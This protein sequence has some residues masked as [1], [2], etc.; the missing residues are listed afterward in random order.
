MTNTKDWKPSEAMVQA[1]WKGFDDPEWWKGPSQMVK[2]LIAVRPLMRDE[3]LTEEQ[4]QLLAIFKT[5][6][7]SLQSQI[8]EMERERI[9]KHFEDKYL[10]TSSMGLAMEIRTLKDSKL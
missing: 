10:T 1:A 8:K 4:E 2:A 5:K 3:I 9:A 6:I 7:K